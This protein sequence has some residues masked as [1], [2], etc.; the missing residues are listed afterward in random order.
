MGF[1]LQVAMIVA[2]SWLTHI[3]AGG[4]KDSRLIRPEQLANEMSAEQRR[5]FF[6]RLFPRGTDAAVFEAVMQQSGLSQRK[7][8]P[9]SGADPAVAGTVAYS[10]FISRGWLSQWEF[11][12]GVHHDADN[13]IISV[14]QAD[15]HHGL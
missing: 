11:V 8:P 6:S 10:Q 2:V 7:P 9:Y 4:H 13:K 12:V 15:D 5:A 3:V 14:F 1:L